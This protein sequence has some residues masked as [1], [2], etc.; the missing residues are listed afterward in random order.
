MCKLQKRQI[1][2][3]IKSEEHLKEACDLLEYYDEE[4]DLFCFKIS[5]FIDKYNYMMFM[6]G[7]WSMWLKT[8][9]EVSLEDLKII[10]RNNSK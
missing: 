4:I 10:L 5:K 8:R 9:K 3:L 2:V 7:K 1:C 6:D